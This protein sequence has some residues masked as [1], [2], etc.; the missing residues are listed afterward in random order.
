MGP[1]RDIHGEEWFFTIRSPHAEGYFF[2]EVTVK[3]QALT[4]RM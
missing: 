1:W 4:E 2:T 3:I